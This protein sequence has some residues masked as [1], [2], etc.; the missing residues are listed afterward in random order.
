MEHI[1]LCV[2]VYNEQASY[3]KCLQD[4]ALCIGKIK[5]TYK[6]AGGQHLACSA[7]CITQTCGKVFCGLMMH[8][9]G[10]SSIYLVN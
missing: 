8:S 3:P 7:D 1:T 9:V 6:G 5:G 4:D 10:R 2:V